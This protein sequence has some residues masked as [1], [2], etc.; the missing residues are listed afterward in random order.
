M[1]KF[2]FALD[3]VL[4]YKSQV[5]DNLKNEHMQ[6]LTSILKKEKEIEEHENQLRECMDNYSACKACGAAINEIKNHEIYL[7]SLHHKIGVVKHEL[8]MLKK[9]EK[10]KQAEVVEAKKEMASIE[11]LKEKKKAQYTKEEQKREE[12]FIEEFVSNTRLSSTRK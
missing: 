10:I 8:Q 2:Y 5:L 12:I 1:K 11:K 6:I 3:T 7:H 9:Q 4:N